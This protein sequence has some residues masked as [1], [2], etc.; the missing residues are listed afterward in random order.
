MLIIWKCTFSKILVFIDLAKN[1]RI[2]NKLKANIGTDDQISANLNLF[3]KETGLIRI[4]SYSD[5]GC[6]LVLVSG[7]EGDFSFI[8]VFGV[9][10]ELFL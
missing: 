1:R 7:L 3:Y 10:E 8:S 2:I 6:G 4:K 9:F 5:F